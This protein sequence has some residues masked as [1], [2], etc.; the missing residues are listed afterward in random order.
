MHT[1]ITNNKRRNS[2][3]AWFLS[4]QTG[5]APH[6]VIVRQQDVEDIQD[7]QDLSC[8]CGLKLADNG[9]DCYSHMSRGM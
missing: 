9:P 1:K 7:E 2:R 5:T 8:I 3:N 4:K 6:S